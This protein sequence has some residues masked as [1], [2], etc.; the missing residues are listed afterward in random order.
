[1]HSGFG[2]RVI[3]SAGRSGADLTKL[4]ALETTCAL[5]SVQARM[6]RLGR[7]ITDVYCRDHFMTYSVCV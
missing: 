1:M 2:P 5:D 7:K 3:Q 4:P 6:K